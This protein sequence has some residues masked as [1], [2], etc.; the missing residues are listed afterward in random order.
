LTEDLRAVRFRL[1][2]LRLPPA[3]LR[4]VALRFFAGLM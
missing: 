2:L 4:L 3:L 1:A